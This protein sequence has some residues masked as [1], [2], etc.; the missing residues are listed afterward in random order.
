[1]LLPQH[2]LR[3]N[4]AVLATLIGFPYVLLWGHLLAEQLVGPGLLA[5]V[6]ALLVFDV[7]LLGLFMRGLLAPL[8]MVGRVLRRVAEG[9][10]TAHIEHRYRGEFGRMLEDVN[11]SIDANRGMMTRV[12]DNTVNVATSSFD[13]VTAAAKVVF[14]VEQEEA[15]VRSISE[16]SNQIAASLSGIAHSAGEADSAAQSAADVVHEGELRVGETTTSMAQLTDAVSAAAAQ[17]EALGKSSQRIGEISGVIGGIAEQTNLLALNAAIEAARAGEH[18]RG[19]AVVADEVR[20]LAA[21]STAATREIDATIG[22]I[23]KQIAEVIASMET[24]VARVE[25]GRTATDRTRDA[26]DAI[27]EGIGMATRQIRQI[28][29]AVG[30]QQQ[31]TED[32]VNS[33]QVIATLATGNTQEAY[34]T[35]DAIE[36]MNGLVGNQ[37][38]ILEAFQIPD[39]AVMVAKSDHVL[40]KKRLAELL[41]GRVQMRPEEV[42]D[43]HSC[44]FGKWYDNAGKALFGDRPEF[45]AIEEPHRQIHATARRIVELHAAGEAAEAQELL[46]SLDEPTEQVLANLDRL[47]TGP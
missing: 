15:H 35:V 28:A 11:H 3:F 34:R 1:M 8:D 44:R 23:Q 21:R 9:D 27:R 16:A 31:A 7:I 24:S 36:K 5:W 17:V 47:R 2:S 32:I 18:G 20:N 12:L 19:F 30:E 37:L 33:I 4:V 6:A 26:F 14:N 25:S 42:T 43:H 45:R 29:E 10:L 39:Q 13:T 46:H 22:A 40:W 38:R 41:L